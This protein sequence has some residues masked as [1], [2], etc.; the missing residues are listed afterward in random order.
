M[1][2]AI[3]IPEVSLKDIPL[4][5]IVNYDETNLTDDPGRRQAIF[6]RG[7]KY[8]ERVMNCTKSA[9]SLLACIIGSWWLR[10][11]F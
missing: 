1:L 10:C 6:R 7:T 8:P 2:S 5:N 3:F 4:E 11:Y 9:T